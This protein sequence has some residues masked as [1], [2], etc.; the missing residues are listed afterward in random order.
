M[1]DEVQK[2]NSVANVELSHNTINVN[3]D[4]ELALW[5][6]RRSTADQEASCA[7]SVLAVWDLSYTAGRAVKRQN[8]SGRQ[9]A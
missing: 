8:L 1:K 4:G 3:S 2:A 7:G 9:F 6:H 5:A